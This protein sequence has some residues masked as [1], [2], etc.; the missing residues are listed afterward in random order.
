[1]DV[2]ETEAT[3]KF[4]KKKLASRESI[5]LNVLRENPC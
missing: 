5:L 2:E 4:N 3:V 1:M